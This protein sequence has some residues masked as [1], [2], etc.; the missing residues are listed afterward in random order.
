MTM[1]GFTAEAAVYKST[2][3]Y[4]RRAWAVPTTN[5]SVVAPQRA[6]IIDVG[7]GCSLDCDCDPGSGVCHCDTT[8]CP[9]F[10]FVIGRRLR[11]A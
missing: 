4:L 11:V 3:S 7:R 1:P 6:V 9:G 10:P 5:A 2:A 8:L